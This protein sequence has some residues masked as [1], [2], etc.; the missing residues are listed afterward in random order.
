MTIDNNIIISEGFPWNNIEILNY[1]SLHTISSMKS[2]QRRVL[3]MDL[4]EDRTRAVSGSSD[5]SLRVWNIE[6]QYKKNFPLKEQINPNCDL[7]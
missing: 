5:N 6:N 7:R 1:E 2:H 3:Y 4:N